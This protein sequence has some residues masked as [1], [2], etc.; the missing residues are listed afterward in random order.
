MAQP[1]LCL[2][3]S[4]ELL[5]IV[6][7]ALVNYSPILYEDPT[8]I[9]LDNPTEQDAKHWVVVCDVVLC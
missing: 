9:L 6:L 4:T 1:E 3:C 2:N 5:Y 8:Q 7:N